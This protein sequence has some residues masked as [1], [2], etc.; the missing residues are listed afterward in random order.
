MALLAACSG[1]DDDNGK[2]P[3]EIKGSELEYVNILYGGNYYLHDNI[4]L[5]VASP[6]FVTAK[7]DLI[8]CDA[9]CT[10]NHQKQ[11][12]IPYM[13]IKIL[14]PYPNGDLCLECSICGAQYNY[15]SGVARNDIGKGSKINIY[16][17]SYNEQTDIYTVWK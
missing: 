4:N 14:Q 13:R 3:I 10:L 6:T 5:F 12:K 8:S 11:S 9:Y 1:D 7:G 17:T 16:K 15:Y 2:T